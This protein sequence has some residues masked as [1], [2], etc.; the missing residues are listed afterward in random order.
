M[1]KAA[2]GPVVGLAAAINAVLAWAAKDPPWACTV[3]ASAAAA[4]F[5]LAIGL[6]VRYRFN[7]YLD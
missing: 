6:Y 2:A 3:L 4:C 1:Q 7:P 5:I